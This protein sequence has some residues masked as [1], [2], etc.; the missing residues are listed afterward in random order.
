MSLINLVRIRPEL[1]ATE[2][3]SFKMLDAAQTTKETTDTAATGSS[4]TSD[5]LAKIARYVPTEIII[6][7]TFILTNLQPDPATGVPMAI[8]WAFL[9]FTPVAAWFFYAVSCASN[10]LAMPW[11]PK[12][13][14][15][16]KMS[17]AS[18]AFVTWSAAMPN[19]AFLHYSWYDYRLSGFA[20]L[21]VTLFLPGVETIVNRPKAKK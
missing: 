21:A 20:L 8:F 17:A 16:W 11:K 12:A 19:S 15:Y 3:S 13:W 7:Y 6:L 14:P 4:A 1:A 10:G 18:V 5:A 9:A 2:A